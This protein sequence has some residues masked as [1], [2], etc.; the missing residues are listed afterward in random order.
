MGVVTTKPVTC[1]GEPL[2]I[3]A[4]AKGGAV[5]ISLL[6]DKGRPVD[7]AKPVTADVTDGVISWQDGPKL[8]GSAG[9]PVRLRFELENATLY[10]FRF[11]E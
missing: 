10:S 1:G 7:Q 11:G 2:H 6:D 5:R 9:K 4:D 3:T 8:A